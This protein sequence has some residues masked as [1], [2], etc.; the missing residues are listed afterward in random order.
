M[1]TPAPTP[2][3]APVAAA[4]PAPAPAE[5][6]PALYKD[7]GRPLEERVRDLVSRLTLAEKASLLIDKAPAIERLGIPAYDAWNEAL[8]G[9]SWRDGV[10]VFP[11][12][13]GLASSWDPELMQRVATAISTEARALYNDGRFGLTLWSPVI[14]LARDPRWGRTQE[15]YGE[16]PT[17]VSRMAVAYVKGIQGDHPFYLRAVATP[18]HYALNNVEATRFTGSSDAPEEVIRDYYLPQFRAAIVEGGAQSIMCSYNRVNGVPSCGNPWLLDTVLR[19]EWGFRG[20]VV[21]DCGAIGAMVWGHHLKQNEEEATLAGLHA[22]C[23][24]ECGK[25]YSQQIA[26]AVGRGALA[27]AEVDR[28]LSRVLTARFR[29]GMFDPKERNPYASIP[30][31]VVDSAEHRALALQATRQSLVLLKNSG[32]LPLDP[33][34]TK[35]LA[36][37]GPAAGVFLHGSTGYH[38]TNQHLVT[39][40]EGIVRRAGN[41]IAVTFAAGTALPSGEG[42]PT[43]AVPETMLRTPSGE[44][45][46]RAEYFANRTLSGTPALTRIDS[47]LDFEWESGSAAPGLPAD[48][49]SVRWTGKLIA[50]TSGQYLL[51]ITGDDGYRLS[52]DGKRLLEDWTDHA[53]KARGLVTTLEAGHAY[54]LTLEYYEHGGG[55]ALHF[56]YAFVG[57]G[58]PDAIKAA[59][60]ADTVL[61]FAGVDGLAADEEK[62]FP[63]LALSED[64]SKLLDAVMKANPRTVL[65]LQSGNPLVLTRR[66][67]SAPAILQAWYAGQDAGTVIAEVLFG[68]TNPSGKLPL[69]FYASL[70][71]LPPMEDYDV[72]KGR[73]YMYLPNEPAFAFGHG[74]S[75]TQFAYENLALSSKG[76]PDNGT[77]RIEFDVVNSGARAGAEVAQVYVKPPRGPKQVLRAFRRVTLDPG[78]KA[79]V[80]ID[81]A[82]SELAHYDVQAKQAL[83]DPGRYELQ[84][85]ASSADIR[86]R[87]TFDVTAH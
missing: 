54:D 61:F 66:E 25:A 63:S 23:D 7:A 71:D 35:K 42:F 83:V 3:G 19:K 36:V 24:L 58:V 84:L 17:L 18:K 55:A 9:V 79:H 12:A 27:E 77:L 52:L 45:G 16:D 53:P 56:A 49:F 8:H 82:I 21:S 64:Q 4:A 85:G 29:L 47:K 10:T 20:F 74:L 62:D 1:R 28:A 37:I 65:V 38:G 86:R 13:I 78:K 32:I 72:R 34:K 69:T 67:K 73:T 22:G 57:N 60:E 81:L 15:G 40:R 50:K 59:R 2:G 39:P 5:S 11:Q 43:A 75:Y 44:P 80:A 6:G 31:S 14:N 33:K 70:A 51:S 46:L 26:G 87:A 76:V 41:A 30:M 48:D 68:D